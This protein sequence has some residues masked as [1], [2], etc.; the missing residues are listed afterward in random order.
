VAA[1]R[2][3]GLFSRERLLAIA[4][5]VLTG[6]AIYVCFLVVRPLVP[7]LAWA[8]A[9]AVTTHPA[10]DWL[11]KRVRNR[12]VAAAVAV[13]LVAVTLV[14]PSIFV[15]QRLAREA[16]F[17]MQELEEEEVQS[18]G[19]RNIVERI[20]QA[21]A[22]LNWLDR[23]MNLEEEVRRAMAAVSSRLTSVVVGS[24]RAIIELLIMFFILFYFF[25][26][27]EDALAA[28]RSPCLYPPRSQTGWFG[29]FRIRLKPSSTGKWEWRPFRGRWGG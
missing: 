1:E 26:D 2:Q 5:L 29:C 18:G 13:L 8:L 25:R 14:A 12:N 28:V 22:V 4:L 10:Y 7:A 20:P 24:A 17:A 9:L 15:L 19:W 21:A 6:I 23:R 16:A 11:A 3:P 27:R